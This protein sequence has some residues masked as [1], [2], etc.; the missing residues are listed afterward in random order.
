MLRMQASAVAF[1]SA[2]LVSQGIE[3]L[4]VDAGEFM[5]KAAVRLR[6]RGNR[7]EFT[8]KFVLAGS[9]TKQFIIAGGNLSHDPGLMH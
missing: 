9:K 4:S 2:G 1:D 6:I 7:I 3:N 8:S 5:G